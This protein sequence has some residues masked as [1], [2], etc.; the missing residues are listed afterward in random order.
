[1]KAVRK[2]RE[3]AGNV[4]LTEVDF[5]RTKDNE[6]LM[7][8]WA[9][10]V[11]GSDLMIQEDRH[12]YDAPV[13]L[14]HEYS[15]IVE[16]IGSAVTSVNIGDKIVSDIE[17]S[18]G[19]IGVQRDG[20]YASHMVIPEAQVHVCPEEMSL[21]DACFAEQLVGSIHCLQE[22]GS[23]RAGDF[24]VVVGPGPA[25]LMN[26]Q[27]AKF[28][29]ATKIALVGLKADKKR[30]E[31]GKKVGA[32]YILYAD[33]D[34][35]DAVR[36]LNNGMGADLVLDVSASGEGFQHAIDCAM[37]T[38]EGLGGR[39]TVISASLWGH[40]IT[41]KA[42]PVSLQQLNVI[43]AWSWN[44]PDTWK[45]AVD[46]LSTGRLDLNSLLTNRYNI[47]EWETAFANLRAKED[48][49]AFIHPNGTDW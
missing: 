28:C 13:T 32:D 25:G 2:M 6:V 35:A 1:M 34:P 26:V 19:W 21:D 37:R 24:I 40:E 11:C 29:G 49:K 23:L 18:E 10:G 31:I 16:E 5:P 46:I 22:R 42:D 39:G 8:V 36:D 17:T 9:A 14:G 15:G 41:L 43:G 38:P 3:G 30:L 45:R 33:E 7:K 4:E 44:G 27:F 12:F 20:A 48:V 47:D